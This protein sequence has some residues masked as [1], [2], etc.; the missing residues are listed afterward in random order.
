MS[1]Y[2]ADIEQ[3]MRAFCQSLRENDRR[4][5]AAVEVAKLGHGG[6][7]YISRIL[8][9]DPKTIRQGRRDLKDLPDQPKTRVR[10]PGGGRK[11]RLEHEPKI[12]DDFQEVLA[13]QTAGSPT[14]ESLIWT[15]LT[16]TEIVD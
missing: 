1:P 3:D 9:I 8:G 7:E 14:D 13:D 15:N 12:G 10:K 11:P 6:L 2:P 16:R 4:R 5:Y